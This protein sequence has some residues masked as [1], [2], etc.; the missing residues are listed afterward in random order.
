L[1]KH[2]REKLFLKKKNPA[3]TC[4]LN[5]AISEIVLSFEIIFFTEVDCN[6]FVLDFVGRQV[7][8]IHQNKTSCKLGGG[9]GV[10]RIIN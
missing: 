8:K 1:A 2:Q 3:E 9:R 7:A 6:E 10:I 5:M 4:C